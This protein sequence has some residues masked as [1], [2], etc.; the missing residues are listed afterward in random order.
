M[1]RRRFSSGEVEFNPDKYLTIEALE[2]GLSITS[3]KS[4]YY[5]T[6]GSKWTALVQGVSTPPI[7]KGDCLYIKAKWEDRNDRNE[8]FKISKGCKLKGN[9]MSLFFWDSS[10]KNN[11][12]SAYPYAFYRLFEYNTAIKEV[13]SS[14]LPA[15]TLATACYQ[16]MFSGCSNLVNAPALPATTLASNCYSNMFYNCTSLTT[17]PELPA[18]TLASNCYRYMFE[19]CRSLNYI[20]MLATDLSASYCLDEWVSGVASSGTFVKNP[21]MTTLPTA[22]SSN[23]YVGIP[24]G[25]TVVDDGEENSIFPMYLNTTYDSSRG[26][27]YRDED[28]LSRSLWEW[29]E[30]NRE[31]DPDGLFNEDYIP[32]SIMSQC[33]LYIDDVKVEELFTDGL[34][35]DNYWNW[36][37]MNS[38]YDTAAFDPKR[39]LEGGRIEIW[40]D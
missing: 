37:P 25:W 40:E 23:D 24:N 18:T 36:W 10:D 32:D 4:I 30:Q 5:R 17:A 2:D 3:T 29:I 39:I 21:A 11:D 1:I 33:E 27:Y 7:N 22:T 13:S 38:K 12:L 6:I 16:S 8:V 19:R 20:K 35:S 14:F 26:L 15:T 9:C 34:G 28:D 31:K